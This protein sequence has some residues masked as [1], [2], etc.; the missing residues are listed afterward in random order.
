[1]GW[2]WVGGWV[3]GWVEKELVGLIELLGEWVEE[4]PACSN[5]DSRLNLST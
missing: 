2:D 4:L 1:M 5:E 3:G